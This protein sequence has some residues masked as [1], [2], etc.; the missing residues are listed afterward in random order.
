VQILVK[1]A[2][3]QVRTLRAYVGKGF[4]TIEFSHEL[5]DPKV[6]VNSLRRAFSLVGVGNLYSFVCI[7]QFC[8]QGW[9]QICGALVLFYN[10][11]ILFFE[12]LNQKGNR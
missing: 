12:N 6:L 9:W 4:M 5:V 2:N 10:T 7:N 11:H 1:V 3:T 8:S